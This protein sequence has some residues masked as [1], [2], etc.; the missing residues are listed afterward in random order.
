MRYLRKFNEELSSE[1]DIKRNLEDIL[2]DFSDRHIPVIVRHTISDGFSRGCYHA[3]YYS[4]ALGDEHADID[5]ISIVPSD[6]KDEFLRIFDYMESEGYEFSSMSYDFGG[7]IIIL[8]SVHIG[9]GMDA[10]S[11]QLF[12][13][14]DETCYLKLFFRKR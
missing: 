5:M 2:I 3:Y 14:I 4:I 13:G 10:I 12:N 11:N 8:N 1:E 9:L 6:N 7:S